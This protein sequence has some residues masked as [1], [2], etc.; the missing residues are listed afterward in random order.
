ML[1]PP[2]AQKV[3]VTP[4]C[5]RFRVFQDKP[6]AQAVSKT[7]RPAH[8]RNLEY[9]SAAICF[10]ALRAKFKV[11]SNKAESGALRNLKV[12][13]LKVITLKVTNK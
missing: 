4:V 13:E 11:E 7:L 5:D 6:G 10:D 8:V 12:N 3:Q 2:T 9:V 1:V